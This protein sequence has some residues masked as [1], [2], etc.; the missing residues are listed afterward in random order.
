MQKVRDDEGSQ[1]LYSIREA[2]NGTF[3]KTVPAASLM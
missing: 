1:D 3:I 2:I